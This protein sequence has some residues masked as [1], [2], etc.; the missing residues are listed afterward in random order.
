MSTFKIM[1]YQL[2][3][4]FRSKW[5]FVF[6]GFFW[7]LTD[8]LFRFGGAGDRVIL[9]MMNVVLIVIPL[10]SIILGAMFVYNSREYIELLLVQPVSRSALFAGLFGGLSLPM[11]GGFV[12]GTLL[13]FL[14]NGVLAE[15]GMSMLFL[16]LTGVLLN[17][18]FIAL[19]FLLA[20]K[21]QDKIKGLGLAI[22]V[23]LFFTV[24]YDG[25][26]LLMIYM[27]A[28]YPMQYPVIIASMLNPI[29]LGRIVLLMNFDISALMGFTGAVFQRFFGS[30][31][32]LAMAMASLLV[33]LTIPLMLSMRIFLK[34]DF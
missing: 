2:R 29:D 16:L 13:P 10:I 5:L 23:W 21:N 8:A 19:A 6:I 3:D 25:L 12:V 4:V 7:L 26:I 24:I 14:Y 30:G 18:I 1:K 15:V 27:F 11:S 20:F 31:A 33:W 28:G 34:K 22:G 17:I 9:S 32:G